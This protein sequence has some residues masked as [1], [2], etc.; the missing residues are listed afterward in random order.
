MPKLSA[1]TAKAAPTTADELIITDKADSNN[2]KR[3]TIGSIVN[4]KLSLSGGT[5]TGNLTISKDNPIIKF[6]DTGSSQGDFW[7]QAKDNRFYVFAD[8]NDDSGQKK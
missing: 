1:L 5:M 8:R 6:I 4:D 3:I 2:T 7:I